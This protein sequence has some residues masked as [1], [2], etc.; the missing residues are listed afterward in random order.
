MWRGQFFFQELPLILFLLEAAAEQAGVDANDS[1]SRLIARE[2]VRAKLRAEP[3]HLLGSDGRLD[4]AN[5][6]HSNVMIA[7]DEQ[8]RR[9]ERLHLLLEQRHLLPCAAVS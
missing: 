6:N 5:S 4:I 3:L 8:H 2:P 1:D 9:R 7:R